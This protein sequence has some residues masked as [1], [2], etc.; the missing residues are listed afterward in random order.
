M[1]DDGSWLLVELWLKKTHG[2]E[3][4]WDSSLSISI[5]SSKSLLPILA[6]GLKL[7]WEKLEGRI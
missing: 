5:K 1:V 7:H 2:K 6:S 4:F 3:T